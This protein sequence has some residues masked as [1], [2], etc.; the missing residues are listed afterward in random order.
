[1]YKLLRTSVYKRYKVVY[2]IT[3]KQDS[4]ETVNL[5]T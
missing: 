1:M 4:I 5:R 2:Q 3:D